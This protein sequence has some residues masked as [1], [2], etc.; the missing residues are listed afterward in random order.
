MLRVRER[1]VSRANL[2][3]PKKEQKL[4][5]EKGRGSRV[6]GLMCTTTTS[7]T[8]TASAVASEVESNSRMR[9]INASCSV[10]AGESWNVKSG[11][12]FATSLV[13]RRSVGQYRTW[14]SK[15]VGQ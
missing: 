5:A 10:L 9:V 6:P 13:A 8:K 4:G 3:P 12:D 2:R 7:S 14:P 11:P 1:H 15:R